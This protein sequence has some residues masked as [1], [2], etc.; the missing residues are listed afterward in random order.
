[1]FHLYLN[2]VPDQVHHYVT[3]IS[4]RAHAHIRARARAHTYDMCVHVVGESQVALHGSATAEIRYM[5]LAPT[6]ADT[7]RRK[8]PWN[9][10]REGRKVSKEI[11]AG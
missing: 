1:M 11:T 5:R 7:R 3:R 10:I 9:K 2:R 6:S 4:M 8:G